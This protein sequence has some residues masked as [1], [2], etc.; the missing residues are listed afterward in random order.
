MQVGLSLPLGS[1]DALT[2]DAGPGLAGRV[3]LGAG[4]TFADV[5]RVGAEAGVLLRAGAELTPGAAAPT[6]VGS[7][8]TGG[9]VVSTAGHALRGEVSFRGQVPFTA[10]PAS[11]ELLVGA[12]FTFLGDFEVSA[13]GG[14]GFGHAPGTPAFRALLGFAW[15]PSFADEP[16][17]RTPG[18]EARGPCETPA[19]CHGGSSSR[20]HS[21]SRAAPS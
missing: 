6:V 3:H 18:P 9:V 2:K 17:R 7:A 12:R 21:V 10:S 5:V 1:S 20:W 8:F 4:R 16:P 19:P 13:L 15:A 14:P 11:A